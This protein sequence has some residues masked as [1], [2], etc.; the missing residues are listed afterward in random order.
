MVCS[1]LLNQFNQNHDLILMCNGKCVIL[2]VLHPLNETHV[3]MGI[4]H[5][6][7]V[8]SIWT[9]HA[10]LP[11]SWICFR[12]T[13]QKRKL[14]THRPIWN[15]ESLSK[16]CLI[17]QPGVKMH[18]QVNANIIIIPYFLTSHT[19]LVSPTAQLPLH[20]W[21]PLKPVTFNR[22]FTICQWRA[23]CIGI[24]NQF[25]IQ[26]QGIY[27]YSGLWQVLDI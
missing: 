7:S 5:R 4:I 22:P 23:Q 16:N 17:P 25:E 12:I 1:S 20:K 26:I 21:Q 24:I 3:K 11:V 14:K 19:S 8:L 18:Y 10:F 13:H 9:L 15:S 6:M 2:D 27:A